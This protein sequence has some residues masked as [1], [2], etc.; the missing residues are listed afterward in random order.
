MRHA[1]K[2]A[3]ILVVLAS[4][5]FAFASDK[6]SRDLKLNLTWKG[7]AI[8]LADRRV[9][10]TFYFEDEVEAYQIQK[11]R[12]QSAREADGFLYFLFDVTGWSLGSSPVGH[13]FCGSGEEKNLIWVKVDASWHIIEKQ[14]VL[15]ASC[16]QNIEPH[17]DDDPAFVNDALSF[18]IDDW[19][20]K[21]IRKIEYSLKEPDKGLQVRTEGTLK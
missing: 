18:S 5:C 8:T 19:N 7:H 21:E 2:A 14:S 10:H 11:A 20:K 16:T 15:Y 9:A 1:Y 12:L 6:S 4:C 3:A 13:G 17:A